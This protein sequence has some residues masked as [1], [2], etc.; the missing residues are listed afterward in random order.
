MLKFLLQKSHIKEE[1]KININHFII[2]QTL[3]IIQKNILELPSDGSI[4]SLFVPH[5]QDFIETNPSD[6]TDYITWNFAKEDKLRKSTRTDDESIP[7]PGDP[8]QEEC[9]A[10]FKAGEVLNKPSKKIGEWDQPKIEKRLI[11][12]KVKK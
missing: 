6:F 10:D 5:A 9:F 2:K 4:D 7:Y 11:T 12:R 3:F 8:N 1:V